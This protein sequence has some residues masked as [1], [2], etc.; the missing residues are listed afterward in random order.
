MEKLPLEH[1]PISE[2]KRLEAMNYIT[3]LI[4]KRVT[5]LRSLLESSD[6]L[7]G[8]L[9]V[10]M[11]PKPELPSRDA[12][13]RLHVPEKL[14]KSIAKGLVTVPPQYKLAQQEETKAEEEKED[15]LELNS[16][17]RLPFPLTRAHSTPDS[18]Y[19]KFKS[20]SQPFSPTKTERDPLNQISSPHS[21][22][23]S[24]P[25]TSSNSVVPSASSRL[26]KERADQRTTKRSWSFSVFP[27][28]ND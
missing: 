2:A 20:G 4:R 9:S 12:K 16:V 8:V 21:L 25:R 10:A 15:L 26:D 7:L 14:R 17:A 19:H 24:R 6:I 13:P 3:E 18:S 1:V 5:S 22:M 28:S 11:L 23:V 27:K